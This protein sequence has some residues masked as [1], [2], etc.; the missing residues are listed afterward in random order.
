LRQSFVPAAEEDVAKVGLKASLVDAGPTVG[1]AVAGGFLKGLAG[2]AIAALA[3]PWVAALMIA[4]PFIGDSIGESFYGKAS[5]SRKETN[6]DIDNSPFAPQMYR[7][8]KRVS[9]SQLSDESIK[10]FETSP[11]G[12]RMADYAKMADKSDP[13]NAADPEGAKIGRVAKQLIDRVESGK[14]TVGSDSYK[15]TVSAITNAQNRRAAGY[16]A[17]GA[18]GDSAWKPLTTDPHTG[19]VMDYAVEQVKALRANTEAT[20]MNTQYIK[21]NSYITPGNYGSSQTGGIAVPPGW[22]PGNFNAVTKGMAITM[23]SMAVG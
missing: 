23:G 7:N 20:R 12:K 21:G 18:Q 14:E 10:N 11:V 2:E 22:G 8:G 3:N 5:K 6:Q 17:Q 16:Y 15:R 9:V 1:K 13:N 4:A 19:K